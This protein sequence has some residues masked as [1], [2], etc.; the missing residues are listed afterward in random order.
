M[1]SRTQE[2]RDRK[3]KRFKEHF[4]ALPVRLMEHEAFRTLGYYERSVLLAIAAEYTGKN[5]GKIALTHAQAEERYG[6]KGRN[7]FYDT[8]EELE[9]RGLIR[10]TWAAPRLRQYGDGPSRFLLEWKEHDEFPEYGV[11]SGPATEAWA[12]WSPDRPR[13]PRKQ[14]KKKK[15]VPTRGDGNARSVP[16]G[17]DGNSSSVP[18]GGDGKPDSPYPP[19]VTLIDSR[20]GGTPKQVIGQAD[21]RERAELEG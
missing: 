9:W 3:R 13:Y 11:Q 6:I 2:K 12:Y 16:T 10:R 15:T 18:T 17:G 4:G 1:P 8:L 19:V 20:G 21:T 7:R 5:N 14:P